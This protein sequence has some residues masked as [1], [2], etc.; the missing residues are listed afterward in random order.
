MIL[1]PVLIIL[2]IILAKLK[3]G[4][5]V[6]FL[7]LIATKSIM[8]AFWNIRIGPLS[9]SSF[10]GILIPILFY[11]VLLKRKNYPKSWRTNASFLTFSLS[12]SL[13]LALPV[14][15]PATITNII[16]VLNIFMGF[17]LIPS[18]VTNKE[19]LRQLLIAIIIGGLFPI[20]VSIF[21]FQTGIVFYVRETV[22]LTRYVGFYHDAFPVRFYGF[23][24]LLAVIMYLQLF[25]PKKNLQ[26]LLFALGFSALFSIYLVFSKAGIG[27]IGLWIAFT[28]LFS[29]SKVK[30]TI[31]IFFSLSMVY[32]IF[33]DVVYENIEQLFSKET[34]YQTGEIKDARYTLAGRGYLWE[35]YLNF[36]ANEQPLFFQIFGDGISRP[37]HNEFLRILLLSGM[38]GI[39]TFVLFLF[40]MLITIFKA[41]SNY[42]LFGLMLLSMFV[43]DCIGLMPGNYYFYNIMVWGLIGLVSLNKTL[44]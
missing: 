19:R 20:I 4:I 40:R 12:F 26:Y 17:F 39:T 14:N 28:L 44:E 23:M 36:W 31:A 11:S 38:V 25:K 6:S 24:T 2:A 41:N 27:I 8:D 34:G 15:I 30:Q 32:L 35:E 10:S 21:Q 37:A 33:G 18:L 16:L 22:G 42:K 43:V 9:F 1:I 13:I 29:K 3:K 5:F 7:V